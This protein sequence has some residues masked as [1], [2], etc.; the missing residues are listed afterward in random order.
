[1]PNGNSL[2]KRLT[3]KVIN[4]FGFLV[5]HK[6]YNGTTALDKYGEP[7]DG[8]LSTAFTESQLKIVIASDKRE[9]DETVIGGLQKQDNKEIL[10]FYYSGA[11][12]VRTGDK[13]IYPVGSEDE[14]IVYYVEPIIFDGVD[15][16]NKAK[17][18][19]DDRY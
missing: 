17:C 18:H 6:R 3:R 15:V 2:K 1:M 19:R 4:K 8:V 11:D 12:S 16:I 14:W 13:I 9:V 10:G 7:V 5:T